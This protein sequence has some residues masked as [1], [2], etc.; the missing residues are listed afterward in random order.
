MRRVLDLYP[1]W[2]RGNPFQ[3]MLFGDL[4]AV[5][6]V[7]RPVP[8]LTHHL[9]GRAS[10]A[11]PG[12]LNLHWTTPVLAPAHSAAE[13]RALLDRFADGLQSFRDAG[14]RL[15]W[16]VHNVLP[17]DARYV[18]TEIRLA[19]LLAEH[20]DLVHVMSEV[21]TAAASP[22]Y[23]LD[24]DRLVCIPHSSYVGVYRD[25]ISREGARRRLG[26]LPS[27]KVLLA[28]GQMRPSRVWTSC[29]TSWR[30]P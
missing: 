12:V 5:D 26:L 4:E 23:R 3:A 19:G 2:R 14:G 1:D 6:A 27:E 29:W 20:A 11:D 8:D 30:T 21:T 16:T 18:D 7:A 25:W 17:H 13:A 24:P 15:V 9:S 10:T 28:L 22:Y